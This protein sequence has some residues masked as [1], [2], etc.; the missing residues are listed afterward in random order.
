MSHILAVSPHLDDAAFSIGGML[1]AHARGGGR[2]TI[3]TCFTA[4]MPDPAGFALACQLDKG[5]G[6]EVDYM[7]LRRAEDDAACAVIG[8]RAIHLPLPE[9][10]HRGYDSAPALFAGRHAGDGILPALAAALRD[11]LE[12]SAADVV[13]GPLAIGDHVDHWLVRDALLAAKPDVLLWEDWPYV[14][15]VDRRPVAQPV[16]R[17]VLSEEDRADKAEMCECYASQIGF[18]FGSRA[19]LS[20][21]LD[22]ADSERLHRV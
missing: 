10:P 15:R 6:P 12:D 19:A 22:A 18:Q 1:A 7:A 9:A 14:A 11:A 2:V 13:L 20:A 5:L 16:R 8:A 21:A 17:H 4:T 3:V